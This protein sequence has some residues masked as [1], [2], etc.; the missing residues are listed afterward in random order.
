MNFSKP[1]FLRLK[2][3][4]RT[5]MAATAYNCIE[6]RKSFCFFFL[7]RISKVQAQC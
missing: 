7:H 6:K 2:E 3:K 5:S 4:A 1:A